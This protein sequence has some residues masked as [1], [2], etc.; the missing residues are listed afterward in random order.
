MVY[1]QLDQYYQDNKLTLFTTIRPDFNP[2]FNYKGLW[3]SWSW[4]LI[5]KLEILGLN[6]SALNRFDL[7][8]VN[9]N[10]R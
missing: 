2:F 7:I 6:Y 9:D 8:Y 5:Q 3:H 4:D 1:D 10:N